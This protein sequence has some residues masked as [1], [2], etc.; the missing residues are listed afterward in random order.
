MLE[1]RN[2]WGLIQ[3]EFASQLEDT[4]QN[5]AVAFG[6]SVKLIAYR[7]WSVFGVGITWALIYLPLA[8][9]D[10]YA[11]THLLHPMNVI[12]WYF[13]TVLGGFGMICYWSF[14][15]FQYRGVVWQRELRKGI[16]VWYSDGVARAADII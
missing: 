3:W 16:A 9:H 11:L 7:I 10:G 6:S 14:W 12:R 1:R 5:Q 8:S 15:T 4:S 13:A 2:A